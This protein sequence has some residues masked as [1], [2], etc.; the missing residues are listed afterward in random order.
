MGDRNAMNNQYERAI[1]MRLDGQEWVTPRLQMVISVF[2][3]T[4]RR[5]GS[6]ISDA[7]DE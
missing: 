6:Q 5:S 1:D 4:W 2:G 3:E 7:G